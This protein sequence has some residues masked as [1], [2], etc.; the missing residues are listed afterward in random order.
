METKRP[1]NA[2]DNFQTRAMVFNKVP[3][4]GATAGKVGEKGARK[5]FGKNS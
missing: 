4:G 2:E 5:D 1:E 3:Q